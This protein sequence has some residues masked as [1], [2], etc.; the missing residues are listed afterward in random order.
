M[1]PL[2]YS[3]WGEMDRGNNEKDFSSQLIND[4]IATITAREKRGDKS[5]HVYEHLEKELGHAIL[6]GILPNYTDFDIIKGDRPF[7]LQ[8]L[9]ESNKF[10][11]QT[12]PP[13][14][15]CH[16]FRF[17]TSRRLVSCIFKTAWF[18]AEL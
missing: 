13:R 9:I 15:S 7:S 10:T 3:I 4:F 12:P 5:V 8:Y 11:L 1:T 2:I 14:F 17:K 16:H 18:K 6:H